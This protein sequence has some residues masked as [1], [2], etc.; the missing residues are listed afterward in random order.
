[1][2]LPA[3]GGGAG[4]DD[5]ERDFYRSS[6]KGRVVVLA[7]ADPGSERECR[8]VAAELVAA[9][10][11]VIVVVA[12]GPG[13]VEPD[14]EPDP[15]TVV[16]TWRRLR[17]GD[18][19]VTVTGA[20]VVSTAAGLAAASRAH[21]LVVVDA[22]LVVNGPDGAR[23]SFVDV[24][25][26]GLP[27]RLQNLARPLYEGVEGLNVVGA[28]DLGR[29]LFTY[30]GAGTLMTL[31]AYG[32]VRRLGFADYGLVA[33]LLRR[34]A[35]LGYL[36]PRDDPELE[37]L[38]PRSL[39]FFA[40]GDHPAGVV[41]L[42]EAPYRGSGRGELE[43]L[44]TISRFHG[45]GV[46]RRLVEALDEVALSHGLRGLFAVTSRPEAAEFFR[47]CGY[48]DVDAG[49]LPAA[50]WVDYP[51]ERRDRLICFQHDL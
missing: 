17:D 36:R 51:P 39:G 13:E 19:P 40:A 8:A 16:D 46:G 48:V 35:E 9:G 27:A 4:A 50:K 6:F 7:A 22:D 42:A 38:L 12:G 18:G 11:Q 23:R 41:A 25:R 33:D 37:S 10:A 26:A 2:D 34:G 5:P 20:D 49:A 14:P 32:E 24:G 3:F 29:E 45:E 30:D 1:M 21:K 44:F 31:G 15:D 47:S 43:A 28:G